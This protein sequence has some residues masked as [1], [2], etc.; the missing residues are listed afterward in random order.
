MNRID[1]SAQRCLIA[2]DNSNMRRIVRTCLHAFGIR[3]V[4]EA[5]DGA[6]VLE[7]FTR[8]LPDIIILDWIMPVF[9][10]ADVIRM[11]RQPGAN[12]NPRVPIIVLTA[13]PEKSTVISARE[14]GVTEILVKPVSAIAL[15]QRIAN[16]VTNPR[17]FV[18]TKGYFGPDRRRGVNAK[19]TGPERR[20]DTAQNPIQGVSASAVR[21][22]APP[23]QTN[24]VSPQERVV[25]NDMDRTGAPFWQSRAA[26]QS[27]PDHPRKAGQP[28]KVI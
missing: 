17:P 18:K 23:R 13:H 24:A 25:V 2:D 14:A 5:A 15:Y 16:A 6:D 3:E 19:Y 11:I 10:G 7:A 21:D 26:P 28:G 8:H 1:L 20:G 12:A 4:Y 27:Q 9:G 22:F